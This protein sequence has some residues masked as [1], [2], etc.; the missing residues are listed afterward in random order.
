MERSF[1]TAAIRRDGHTMVPFFEVKKEIP[2]YLLHPRGSNQTYDS[3]NPD[4]A[5]RRTHRTRMKKSLCM[6]RCEP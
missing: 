6:S 2:V 5:D 4:K 3:L 1:R